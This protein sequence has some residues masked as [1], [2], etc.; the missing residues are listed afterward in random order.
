[1]DRAVP[2]G[3]VELGPTG[4][5]LAHELLMNAMYDAPTDSRGRPRYSYDRKQDIVLD[6]GEV[7][8]LRLG[9]D[10]APA[11]PIQVEYRVIVAAFATTESPLVYEQEQVTLS[12]SSRRQQGSREKRASIERQSREVREPTAQKSLLKVPAAKGC[13]G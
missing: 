12:F 13:H 10:G 1:M 7:P 6:E 2:P 9:T 3:V 5:E 11:R 8:T 4:L